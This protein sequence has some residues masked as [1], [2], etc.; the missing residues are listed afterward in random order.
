MTN[1]KFKVAAMS[2]A[3]TACVAAQPLI[4]NAAD[5]E[6]NPNGAPG[7]APQS[8]EESAASVPVAAASVSSDP[9][10]NQQSGGAVD[11]I[12]DP[13]ISV[14][15]DHDNDKVTK[16]DSST[17]TESTGTVNRNVPKESNPGAQQ[18]SGDD[19]QPSGDGQ[20]TE[21]DLNNE[22]EGPKDGDKETEKV[23]I[24]DAEKTET[25]TKDAELVLGKPTT[26]TTT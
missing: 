26:T 9:V 22:Q 8:E 25:E 18:S 12:G 16:D 5:E 21:G 19:Q 10:T 11:V 14:D 24:G 15:Y 1:K 17:T 7:S 23:P 4:A 13:H 2:M 6:I 20:Q 3:L